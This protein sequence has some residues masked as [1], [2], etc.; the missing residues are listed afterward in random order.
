[1]GTGLEATGCER[2]REN[3]V[4]E[5]GSGHGDSERAP[6]PA[7]VQPSES[8]AA[9]YCESHLYLKVNNFWQ[10]ACGSEKN[11]AMAQ[12][13]AMWMTPFAMEIRGFKGCIITWKTSR[14]HHWPRK[15]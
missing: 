10:I 13:T 12:M 1:M 8:P 9:P 15:F 11:V 7:S 3:G 4:H 14:L 2:G 5:A 6:A